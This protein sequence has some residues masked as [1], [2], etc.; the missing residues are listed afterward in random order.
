MLPQGG[1]FVTPPLGAI[2][3]K[4]RYSLTRYC[5]GLDDCYPI[6]SY[7][8]GNLW[9]WRSGWYTPIFVFLVFSI[10][11]SV[12]RKKCISPKLRYSSTRYCAGLDDHYPIMSCTHKNLWTQRL[13][14]CTPIFVFLLFSSLISVFRKKCI[15]PKSR[16]SSTGYCAGLDLCYL[17]MSYAHGNLRTQRSGWYTPIFVFL[18][19]S[20]RIS[21]FC[22][23]CI[24]PK[25]HYLSTW[26]C[27]GLD[28]IMSYTHGN[29]WTRR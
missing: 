12:F 3:P 19:F 11:I 18:V 23:K 27:A 14:W 29:L 15:S 16:Y 20:S 17:I 10:R 1:S 13:R 24:S 28:P 9:T 5:A 4:F 7:T 25:L 6:M 22:K 21:V 26:Y 8:H 2:S